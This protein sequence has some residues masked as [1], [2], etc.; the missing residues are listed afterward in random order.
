MATITLTNFEYL[1]EVLRF[2]PSSNPDKFQMYLTVM[3]NYSKN[4]DRWWLEFYGNPEM[5]ALRQLEE[6]ILL[7][8]YDV[9]QRGVCSVLGRTPAKEELNCSNKALIA[10]FKQKLNV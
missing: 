4:G 3:E 8:P 7:I 6:P 2:K 9:L 1:E 5:L 10:E